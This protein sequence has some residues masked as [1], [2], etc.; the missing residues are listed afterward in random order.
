[1]VA[2]SLSADDKEES[3]PDKRWNGAAR[4]EDFNGHIQALSEIT[5]PLPSEFSILDCPGR[6]GLVMSVTVEKKCGSAPNSGWHGLRPKG[7]SVA[8]A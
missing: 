7:G 2:S 4:V 6:S 3:L 1:M 8:S 5:P